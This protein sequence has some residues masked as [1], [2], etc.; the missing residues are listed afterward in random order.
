[1]AAV[2][3]SERAPN[4]ASHN[5]IADIEEDDCRVDENE[6]VVLKGVEG[7]RSFESKK[8]AGKGV[9]KGAAATM[10]RRTDI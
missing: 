9:S 2:S 5:E 6:A 3:V 4:A 10:A 8:D 7:G 1:M